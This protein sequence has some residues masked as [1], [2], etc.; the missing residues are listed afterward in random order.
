M[1]ANLSFPAANVARLHAP[2]SR[3]GLLHGFIII[4]MLAAM[5]VIAGILCLSSRLVWQRVA[6]GVFLLVP[7]A[8]TVLLH[9]ATRRA[10]AHFQID[11]AR[12]A[13]HRSDRTGLRELQ[14]VK[15]FL[16]VR[17]SIVP[18]TDSTP[19]LA[20]LEL[21]CEDGVIQLFTTPAKDNALHV[22]RSLAAWLRVPFLDEGTTD[23]PPLRSKKILFHQGW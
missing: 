21:E 12:L 23:V 20:L 5:V 1:Y 17:L 11:K 8:F 4:P 22:G 19:R 13:V 9:R 15:A 16:A 10:H 7:A 2:S 18:G 6:V 14:E 3:F